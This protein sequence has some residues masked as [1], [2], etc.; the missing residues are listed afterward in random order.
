M[1]FGKGTG[2]PSKAFSL[3]LLVEP[4]IQLGCFSV[5]VDEVFSIGII[6]V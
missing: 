3:G 6:G 4:P 1:I 2:H 5:L